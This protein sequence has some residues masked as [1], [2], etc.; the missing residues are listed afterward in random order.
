MFEE[1]IASGAGDMGLKLPARAPGAFREY[2]E[3]LMERNQEFNLTAIKGEEDAARLHFLD[4]IALLREYDFSGKRVIDI[5]TGA[6]FPGLPLLIAGPDIDLTLVDSTEKKVN[7]L[8]E[9]CEKTALTARC[10]HGRAEELG[11]DPEYRERFD[12]TVSRAVARLNMLTELCMPF[13]KTGGAFIAMKSAD[14][15]EEINE[16]KSAIKTLGGKISQ[17]REYTLPGTDIL[18]RAV[19]IE[20]TSPTPGKYP[21]RFA[22]LSKAPL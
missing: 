22:K 11:N 20:K 21:R 12:I 10:I 7:F 19:V 15:E 4:S 16:A 6:G 13:V 9:V 2:Y 18:R 14:S 1:I 3:L 5:G 17:V 8:R